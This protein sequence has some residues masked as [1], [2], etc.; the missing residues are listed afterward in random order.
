MLE[1]PR[2]GAAHSVAKDTSTGADLR[3]VSD[4]CEEAD[5]P[6]LCQDQHVLR[7]VKDKDDLDISLES[8]SLRSLALFLESHILLLHSLSFLFFSA[9]SFCR[10]CRVSSRTV[11][12]ED[13]LANREGGSRHRGQ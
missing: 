8:S 7:T 12:S 10:R 11:A 2:R 4:L 9:R 1:P 3:R 6:I 13:V 5:L